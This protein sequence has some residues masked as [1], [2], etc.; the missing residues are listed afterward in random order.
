MIHDRLK[1]IYDEFDHHCCNH[2]IDYSIDADYYNVQGYRLLD[3]KYAPDVLR[4][5]SNY[6]KDRWVDL[7]YDGFPVNYNDLKSNNFN[8]ATYNPLFKFTLKPIQESKMSLKE[9]AYKTPNNAHG[10]RQ[11]AFP[12][13]FRKHK[14]RDT[15]EGESGKKKKKKKEKPFSESSPFEERLSERIDESISMVEPEILF[16][17]NNNVTEI[18]DDWEEDLKDNL[19][20]ESKL[21]TQY[22]KKLEES[23]SE[24]Q[25]AVLES[26]I[27]NCSQRIML[28][29]DAL[30]DLNG[31]N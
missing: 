30:G 31:T 22:V 2:N 1:E 5:M 13:S 9:D 29:S 11:A 27:E 4:H 8:V 10:L 12:S 17:R 23:K 3:G 19:E 15:Y 7:E 18:S 16:T 6:V 26:L 14:T 21:L 20:S 24:Y 28:I 25:A